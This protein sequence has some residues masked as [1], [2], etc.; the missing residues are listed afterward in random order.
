MCVFPRKIGRIFEMVRD[1]ANIT[2]NQSNRK[3]IR[4]FRREVSY[5]LW[6]TSKVSTVTGT[7]QTVARLPYKDVRLLKFLSLRHSADFVLT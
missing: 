1:R 4:P 6:M 7:V 5:Q 3:S 2:I